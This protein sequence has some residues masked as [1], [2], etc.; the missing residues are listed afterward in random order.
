[1]NSKNFKILDLFKFDEKLLI[2]YSII[3]LKVIIIFI[4]IKIIIS[5]GSSIIQRFFNRQKQSKFGFNEKKADTLSELLKSILRYVMYFIGFMWILEVLGLNIKTVI[6]VTSFAGVAVGFGAQ[7][8][9]KDVISGFFILFEDQFAVGDYVEID[10][11]SGFVETVG[12]RVTKLRDF[13]GDLHIIPNGSI[14]RVTNKSRGNMRALVDITISYEE[15][16]DK[17]INIIKDVNEKMKKEFKEIIEGPNVLGVTNFSDYG[18]T[19]RVVAKTEAMK[20]WGIEME[21]R[22]RI[23]QALDE[24]NIE[25]PIPKRIIMNYKKGEKNGN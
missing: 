16:I 6:A 1:M 21:L 25:H 5:I 10:G 17:A 8:F 22:K 24:N 20:Q 18:A 7:N 12:L 14:V 15:D 23:K 13:S 11:L 3:L 4:F 9:I 2:N 19:I